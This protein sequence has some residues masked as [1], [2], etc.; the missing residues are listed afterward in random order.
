MK[1]NK[2][3]RFIKVSLV[4]FGIIRDFHK[5][6]KLI[7]KIGFAATEKKMSARHGKRAKQLYDLAVEM[8]GVLIKMCQMFSTRRDVFPM[9]YVKTLSALQDN[10]PPAS[11][12][13]ILEVIKSQYEDYEKIFN[14]IDPEPLASAS[15]GQVHR[16]EFFD[17]TPVVLKILKPDVEKIIDTDLAILHMVFKVM[18]NFK[19]FKDRSDFFLMLE[20][21]VRVT[22]DELNFKREAWLAER[23][24]KGLKKFTYLKIP[25]VYKAFSTDKIIVMEYLE[26]TKI[27]ERDKWEQRN[28]DPIVISRQLIEIYVEQILNMGIVHFDPH[29]GNILITEN[30]NMILLD[31]G[32]AGEISEKMRRNLIA[33]LDSLLNL[34]YRRFLD[35]LY[36]MGFIR[37]D[38]N[39]YVML[40]VI[41]FFLND[42]LQT[43]NL[44]RESMNSV[45]YSP[46]MNELIEVMYV[47]P[48]TLPI[49][50]A[51]IGKTLGTLIGNI[52]G[53]NPEIKI[54]D[55][56]K[57]YMDGVLRKNSATVISKG[58]GSAKKTGTL[59]LN[60]PKKIDAVIENLERGYL[61]I[62]VDYSEIN[63][64]ID[65]VKEFL[66]RLVSFI[67]ASGSGLATYILF[68]AQ[69]FPLSYIT[70][71]IAVVAFGVTL[72]YRKKTLRQKIEKMM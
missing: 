65:E 1:I 72:F 2:R 45:D 22:G 20:E 58:I 48:F 40:P 62:K 18:S 10:V 24:K 61:K 36:H 41:E 64:K 17:G 9:E 43:I 63:D 42:I 16:G 66:I 53:L 47:Q 26:G 52:S 3:K 35:S 8:G 28:N 5:E 15:L 56:F 31:F 68:T 4:F 69:T 33:A 34:E 29:P 21:F 59:L 50:W 54:Y 60:L 55:E 30:N 37:K 38:V 57:P 71:V 67:I 23:F 44:D 6:F 12:D 13:E 39:R 32:M 19:V 7:K 27:N 51:Y 11:Y 70:L 14:S 25:Y 46:I 49:D